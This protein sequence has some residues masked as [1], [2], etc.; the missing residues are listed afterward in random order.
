MALDTRDKRGSAMNPGLAFGRVLPNP[1]GAI[2]QAARQIAAF[3]YAGIAAGAAVLGTG[4]IISAVLVVR[5]RRVA[6]WR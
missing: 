5:R 4:D 6:T 3:L 2:I 1:G